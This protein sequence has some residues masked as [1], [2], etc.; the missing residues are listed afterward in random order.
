MYNDTI[1]R[2]EEFRWEEYMKRLLVDG[3]LTKPEQVRME[4][5]KDVFQRR[6]RTLRASKTRLFEFVG[7]Q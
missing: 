6:L 1:K 5:M 4:V 2:A 3:K 7:L